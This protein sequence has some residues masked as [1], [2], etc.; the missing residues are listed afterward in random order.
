[1]Y[2]DKVSGEIVDAAMKVHTALGPGLLESAYEFCLAYELRSRGLE[3]QT[4]VP[5]TIRYRD[6]EM[7]CGYRID[8]L[9]ERSIIVA[10]KAIE[11]TK[12]VHEAQL[13]S[14]LRLSDHKVGLLINFHVRYLKDGIKR[15][16][17][18]WQTHASV[19]A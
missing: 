14:H 1:M 5:V 15:M 10:V 18:N 2:P 12:P 16:V 7:E 11:R 17:N 8:M 3:V 9:V 6:V 4:Q 13:L 19:E